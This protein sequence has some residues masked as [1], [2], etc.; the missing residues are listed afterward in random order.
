MADSDDIE[1][2]VRADI[3]E[4]GW[5]VVK[6]MG[7]DT[8]PAW[9]YTIGLHETAGHPEL[10]MF[11]MP[12]DDLHAALNHMGA[13]IRAGRVFEPGEHD[14]VFEGLSCALRPVEQRWMDVFFGNAAWHYKDVEVPLLQCFWPDAAGHFPW[15]DEF[16]A[17]WRD[18]QPQLFCD[19]VEEAL[20]DTL[21]ETL[22]R[23][24]AL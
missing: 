8:A 2:R 16:D 21:A 15:Q 22:R 11:G 18:D 20:S 7:D 23:E 14:G 12:L 1:A 24:G 9:A 13:L 17:S 10:A 6:V 19:A 3:A 5:H 4:H